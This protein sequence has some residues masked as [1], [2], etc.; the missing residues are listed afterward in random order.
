[1]AMTVDEAFKE[2]MD[3]VV[4]LDPDVVTQA[5]KSRDNL[6]EN[7]DDLNQD[8]F[9]RLHK[10]FNVGFGSFSRRTK[11]RELNDI[12]LMIGIA[13]DGATYSEN[14]S[15][16]NIV[17]TASRINKTQQE[18]CNEDGTLN[19][20]KVLNKFKAKL[21]ELADYS[22]SDIHRNGEAV[23]LDLKSKVWSFDIVPCFH[24]TKESDGRNY[25]LIPNANGKWKKTDPTWDAR[26]VDDTVCLKGPLVRPLVRLC[27]KWNKVKKIKNIP[28]YLLETMIVDFCASHQTLN[29]DLKILFRQALAYIQDSVWKSVWD[30]KEI[31]GDINNLQDIYEFSDIY[32]IAEKAKEDC[33]KAGAAI[34]CKRTKN[35]DRVA[36]YLWQE[37]FGQ[38]FPSYDK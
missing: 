33:E 18:C 35:D 6:L 3:E 13:A 30:M 1:M 14:G 28:S 8:D 15:W 11:C 31:E 24:T 4:N 16:D 19:S 36:I 22:R 29:T 38:D 26:Y 37:I 21:R 9:F 32:N 27:K 7:I 23:T 10:E 25:Y 20:T 5:R 17:M 2:F 34:Y 12:D